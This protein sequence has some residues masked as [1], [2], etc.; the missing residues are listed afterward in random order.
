MLFFPD[1]IDYGDISRRGRRGY[2]GYRN[3]FYRPSRYDWYDR[4]FW[5]RRRPYFRYRWGDDDDDDD[6]WDD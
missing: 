5:R 1:D 3:D 4:Y 2:R 6:D